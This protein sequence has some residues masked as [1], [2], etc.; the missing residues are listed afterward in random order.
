MIVALVWLKESHP[1]LTDE[2]G[3]KIRNKVE[4]ESRKKS[5][6]KFEDLLNKSDLS[7]REGERKS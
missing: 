5:E 2:N 3:K 1:L 6:G 4:K 7:S